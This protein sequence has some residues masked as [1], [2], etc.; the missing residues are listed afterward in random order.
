MPYA[1]SSVVSAPYPPG[2]ETCTCVVRI[3]YAFRL[4]IA[5]SL[6]LLYFKLHCN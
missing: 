3:H 6:T 2:L 5:A 4:P 1:R